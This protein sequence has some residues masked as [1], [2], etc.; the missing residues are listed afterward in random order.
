MKTR[1]A[2]SRIQW[3]S[4]Q[5]TAERIAII[6]SGPS[7]RNVDLEIPQGITVIA[8]N[9]GIWLLPEPPSF[10]FTM[11]VTNTTS[12]IMSAPLDGT[13]YYAAVLADAQVPQHVIALKRILGSGPY[14][15]KKELSEDP[16]GVHGGNSGWGAL[17]LA[18]LMQPKRVGLFGIDGYGGYAHR[19]GSPAG[20]F[21]HLP[22]LFQSA[23]AQLGARGIDVV[24]G[25]PNSRIT[26]WPRM[27]PLE[28]L[29]WL[30][31]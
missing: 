27:Q 22:K 12:A 31:N 16:T 30:T 21:F 1:N 25:S 23:S 3:G 20:R 4:V 11:D 6:G 29:E 19:N 26:A 9:E 17:G 28:A 13:V 24:N 2:P 14:L 10:W 5:H 15:S 8:V 18:Y 7:L